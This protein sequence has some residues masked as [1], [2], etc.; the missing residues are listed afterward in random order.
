MKVIVK[1][2]AR[3]CQKRAGLLL[4]REFSSGFRFLLL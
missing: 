3:R 2:S 1:R 4:D